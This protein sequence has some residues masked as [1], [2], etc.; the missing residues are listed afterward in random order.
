MFLNEPPSSWHDGEAALQVIRDYVESNGLLRKAQVAFGDARTSPRKTVLPAFH[1]FSEA[2]GIRAIDWCVPN[3]AS[4]LSPELRQGVILGVY[5]EFVDRRLG[6]VPNPDKVA[7]SA[8]PG[9]KGRKL[10]GPHRSRWDWWVPAAELV[11]VMY[12]T[13]GRDKD[14]PKVVVTAGRVALD[15]GGSRLEVTERGCWSNLS[16]RSDG[17]GYLKPAAFPA[18]DADLRNLTV[19]RVIT[20]SPLAAA[21]QQLEVPPSILWACNSLTRAVSLEKHP[22]LTIQSLEQPLKVRTRRKRSRNPA[23]IQGSILMAR[24]ALDEGGTVEEIYRALVPY[25]VTKE[26]FI[27]HVVHP[28]QR[29]ERKLTEEMRNRVEG[30]LGALERTGRLAETA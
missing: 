13:V 28:H 18:Q 9:V 4:K 14:D 7:R 21:L 30:L 26:E 24:E 5:E 3:V 16:R 29:K 19:P 2:E 12:K 15:L 22:P 6:E 27:E 8:L 25:A 1:L 20:Y 11:A 17:L 23:D 10:F